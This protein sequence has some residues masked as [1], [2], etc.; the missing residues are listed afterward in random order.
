M[1][2]VLLAK[3]VV[4]DYKKA[5]E[6]LD[7]GKKVIDISYDSDTWELIGEELT[8]K[9]FDEKVS[10]YWK[11]NSNCAPVLYCDVLIFDN[12]SKIDIPIGDYEIGIVS[13]LKQEK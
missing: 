4:Y 8:Y 3:K 2:K 13:E 12:E 6:F 5:I 11:H 7:K 10:Y 1:K 9:N